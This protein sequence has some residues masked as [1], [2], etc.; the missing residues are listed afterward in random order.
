VDHRTLEAQGIDRVPGIHVGVSAAAMERKGELTERG[1]LCVFT[2]MDNLMRSAARGLKRFGQVPQ[3]GT[4]NAWWQRTKD[5]INSAIDYTGEF[6]RDESSGGPALETLLMNAPA[7]ARGA[8]PGSSSFWQ[9]FVTT[10]EPH[11]ERGSPDP[12]MGFG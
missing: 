8:E 11:K 7:A 5:V 10:R 1:R 9:D 4:G 2:K 6:L 3:L 12:E